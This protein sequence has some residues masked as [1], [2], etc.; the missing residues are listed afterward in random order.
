M[1]SVNMFTTD[2]EHMLLKEE[3]VYIGAR[4]GKSNMNL[5]IETRNV[6]QRNRFS[7]MMNDMP[8]LQYFKQ[9][10]YKSEIQEFKAMLQKIGK[11]QGWE[12]KDLQQRFSNKT[13]DELFF[14]T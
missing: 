13:W 7:L 6:N 8:A 1:L 5:R 11:R 12:L 14:K 4:N 9:V 10:S 3:C 2:C